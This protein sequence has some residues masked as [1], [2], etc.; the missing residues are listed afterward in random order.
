M[1]SRIQTLFLFLVAICMF[2]CLLL[3]IWTK[4]SADNKVTAEMSAFTL[5]YQ[6][7]NEKTKTNMPVFYIA[8]TALAAGAVSL[9]SVLRYRNQDKN[10]KVALFHQI[11]FSMIASLLIMA[12]V[13]L[14]VFLSLQGEKLAAGSARGTF[15]I[16]FFCTTLAL[17]FNFLASRFIRRDYNLIKS[18]DRLR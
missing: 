8:L 7:P 14:M 10:T 1:F 11:R 12:T 4:K 16:G 5:A 3:P 2:A 15:Q 6:K 17:L 13:S 18:M 9:Y